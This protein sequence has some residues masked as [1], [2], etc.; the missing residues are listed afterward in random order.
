MPVLLST[1]YAFEAAHSEMKSLPP[2]YHHPCIRPAV[3]NIA[4]VTFVNAENLLQL[5]T[6]KEI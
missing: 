4:T 5:T 3:T 6:V 1:F 2:D